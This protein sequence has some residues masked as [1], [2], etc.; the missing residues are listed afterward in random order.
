MRATWRPGWRAVLCGAMVA[1]LGLCLL[2]CGAHAQ[3]NRLEVSLEGTLAGEPHVQC[4]EEARPGHFRCL[5]EEDPGSG[6]GSVLFVGVDE[7]EC[8][9]AS[10]RREGPE[11]VEGCIGR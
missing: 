9:R 6:G 4:E 8:W 10:V 5:V 3:E 2:A 11:E 1:A 7:A